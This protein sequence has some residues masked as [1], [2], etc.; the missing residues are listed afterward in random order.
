MDA[1]I[2]LKLPDVDTDLPARGHEVLLIR[3]TG[4]QP[5][6]K[7]AKLTVS[8]QTPHALGKA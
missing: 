3:I 1:P 5:L 2:P 4:Q 8:L 7:F 6:Q